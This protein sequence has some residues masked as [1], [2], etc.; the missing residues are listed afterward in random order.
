MDTYPPLFYMS[1]TTKKVIELVHDINQIYSENIAAYSVD[2]G[3]NMFLFTLKKHSQKFAFLLKRLF[4]LKNDQFNG[5]AAELLKKEEKD[6]GE[7]YEALKKSGLKEKD[8]EGKITKVL[9]TAVGSGAHIPAGSWNDITLI[10]IETGEPIA[11]Y[12]GS[13][14]V[15]CRT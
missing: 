8:F 14:I 13:S 1:N 9:F 5:R 10:N 3:E 12:P 15:F 6:Y 4:E 7:I 11:K 2:A